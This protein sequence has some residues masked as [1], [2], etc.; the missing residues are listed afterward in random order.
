MKSV[1]SLILAGVAALIVFITLEWVIALK[2][3][4][5]SFADAKTVVLVRDQDGNTLADVSVRPGN[6]DSMARLARALEALPRDTTTVTRVR[7]QAAT[8][9]TTAVQ[10]DVDTEATAPPWL[11]DLR[12]AGQEGLPLDVFELFTRMGDR[13]KMDVVVT[14]GTR[15]VWVGSAEKFVSEAPSSETLNRELSKVDL[16]LQLTD[17]R[18]GL[19]GQLT[20]I[21]EG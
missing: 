7:L 14:A 4:P 20:F 11:R 13:L 12:L 6:A 5:A 16:D 21:T 18:E 1:Y 3:T 8:S 10:I 15:P 2:A 17:D 19:E 9:E